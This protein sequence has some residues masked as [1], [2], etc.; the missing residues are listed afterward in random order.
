MH[1]LSIV[2]FCDLG[3]GNL[4]IEYATSFFNKLSAIHQQQLSSI[5]CQSN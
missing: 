3:V 5:I 4:L 1:C 2:L